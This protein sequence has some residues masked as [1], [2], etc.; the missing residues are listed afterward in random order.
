MSAPLV[1]ETEPAAA[2][3]VRAPERPS[4]QSYAVLAVLCLFAVLDAVDHGGL[5]LVI[6]RIRLDLHLSQIQASFILGFGSTAV[7]SLLLLPAGCVVDLYSRRILLFLTALGWSVM[8]FANGSAIGF[9]SLLFARSGT[10]A[11]DAVLKPASQ[12]MLRDAFAPDS[13]GVPFS[14]YWGSFALG[15]GLSLYL[16]GTLIG[17][18][19]RHY[20][21]AWPLL[22]GFSSWQIVLAVPGMLTLPLAFVA[23]LI[24]DP[25]REAAPAGT[26]SGSGVAASIRFIAGRWWLYWPSFAYS[27]VWAIPN[28]GYQWTPAALIHGWGIPASRLGQV[29]GLLGI[30]SSL[31]GIIGGG[32]LVDA[33]ARRGVRDVAIRVTLGASALAALSQVAILHLQTVRLVFGAIGLMQFFQGTINAAYYVAIASIT[34]SRFMGRMFALQFICLSLPGAFGPTLIALTDRIGYGAD[35]DVGLVAAINLNVGA[36]SVIYL[37][38]LLLLVVRI[39]RFR[40]MQNATI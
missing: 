5:G 31:T 38:L 32:W 35:Q 3:M 22:G 24:R 21:R 9:W 26:T 29:V 20:F 15:G 23:L 11:A 40:A 8:S 36:G 18:A 7:T 30:V 25:R 17:L 10:A 1:R 4:R 6:D 39:G 13:R 14:L 28:A 16:S 19:D 33:L 27:A 2:D 34:P 12:S 37:L